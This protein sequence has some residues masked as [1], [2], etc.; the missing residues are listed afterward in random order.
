M[1]VL[2][3]STVSNYPH[4]L[5]QTDRRG[6]K[7]TKKRNGYLKAEKLETLKEYFY[8]IVNFKYCITKRIKLYL[9]SLN[10]VSKF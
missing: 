10:A 9:T 5:A 1:K 3:M 7:K 2:N 4:Y 6:T 8:A